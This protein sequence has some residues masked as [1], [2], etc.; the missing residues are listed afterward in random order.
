[1]FGFTAWN[2]SHATFNPPAQ[3]ISGGHTVTSIP[4][5]FLLCFQ[6]SPDTHQGVRSDSPVHC[7][8]SKLRFGSE[9]LHSEGL[10]ALVTLVNEAVPVKLNQ[11]AKRSSHLW[12]HVKHWKYFVIGLEC[13]LFGVLCLCC[14]FT[15]IIAVSLLKHICFYFA[16]PFFLFR[17]IFRWPFFFVPETFFARCHWFTHLLR[18][19]FKS[20]AHLIFLHIQAVKRCAEFFFIIIISNNRKRNV[21]F[22]LIGVCWAKVFLHHNN[23]WCYAN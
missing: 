3:P 23:S 19:H 16:T 17:L 4:T 21:K 20:T 14:S 13:V 8:N 12:V 22:H 5:D 9:R 7:V 6:I 15:I 10:E 2:A 11:A 18:K 1:M